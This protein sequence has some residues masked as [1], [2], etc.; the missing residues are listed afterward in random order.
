MPASKAQRALTARRRADAIS[1]KLAGADWQTIAAQLGYAGP[2]A[3]C[4]DVTRALEAASGD[5]RAAATDLLSVELA[6]LDRLQ[7]AMWGPALAGDARSAEVVLKISAQRSRLLR[8]GEQT[9]RVEEARSVVGAL[10]ASLRSAYASMGPE[11]PS[12]GLGAPG[13]GPDE[14]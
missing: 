3:A 9:P 13:D 1:L 7:V 14:E 4:K 5:L 2:A 10:A 8:L 12:D 6:R 11:E